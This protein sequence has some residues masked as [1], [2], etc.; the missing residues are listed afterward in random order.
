MA[1][2]RTTNRDAVNSAAAASVVTTY[3]TGAP[4]AGSLL[5]AAAVCNVATAGLNTLSDA[6]GGTWTTARDRAANTLDLTIFYKASAVGNE[7][8]VT[9]TATGATL[10]QL[11][12]FAYTGAAGTLETA[13]D[14]SAGGVTSNPSTAI[15]TTTAADLIFEVGAMNGATTAQSWTTATMLSTATQLFPAQYLPAGTLTS[16][17]DTLSWTTAR[18][19]LVNVAAFR[20]TVAAPPRNSNFALWF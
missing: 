3:G 9:L 19:S 10:C 7:T 15:S 16:Y 11:A 6:G 1:I 17:V 14:H 2:A 4:A 20:P 13:S 12:I 8:T 18:G 5:I